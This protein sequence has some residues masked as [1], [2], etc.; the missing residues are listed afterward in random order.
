MDR[1]YWHK[2]TAAEPLFPDLEWSRPQTAATAGKLMIVGGNSFG[3]VAPATAFSEAEKA[4]VGSVQ[5]LL[6]DSLRPLIGKTFMAGELAAS[7]PSGSFSQKALLELLA[8]SQWSDGVLFA[9]D[10][11]RNSETASV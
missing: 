5:M 6:P 7:T 2:Q 10:L 8:M 11:G 4:G 1:T 9:G 3:F